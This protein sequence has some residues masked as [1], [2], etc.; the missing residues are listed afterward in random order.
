MTAL[1]L[2]G[3]EGASLPTGWSIVNPSDFAEASELRQEFFGFLDAW[4]D[5]AGRDGRSFNELF[6]V[7]DGYS[8]W[9]T[10]VAADRQ[11]TRGVVKYFRYAALVDRAVARWKPDSIL[12]FTKDPLFAT[13]LRSRAQH[14]G[15]A[16]QSLQGC[17][18]PVVSTV[19]TGRE[20]L[21]RSFWHALASP[22]QRLA[23]A[24]RCRWALR[25][26][27]LFQRSARPTVVFAS[28]WP[29][30]LAVRNGQ[31]SRIYW[32]EIATAL[33][34][35]EPPLVQAYLPRK[36]EEI[37]DAGSSRAG[38]DAIKRVRA[39][40]LIWERFFPLRGAFSR[41][42]RQIDLLWRFTRL[43]Q[44]TEFHESFRYANTNLA[45]V[46][47]PDLKTGVARAIDWSFKAAQ[48]G[49]ALRAAGDVKVVLVSEEM[50]QPAMPTLSAA[51]ALGIP[52][53]GVQHGTIMPTHFMYALP[54]GH[55]Q[56]A[57]V[58]DYFCAYGEYATEVLSV[59]GCYPP[60]RVWITGA[61]RLDPLVTRLPDQSAARAALELPADA[62]IV[63]LATQ[64]FPWF[65]SAMRAVLECMREHP[66]ALLCLKR[67][68]S[69]HAMPLTQ[70]EAMAADLGVRNVRGFEA[71]TELLLAACSVWISAS[72]TTILEATLIGRPTICLNFS[73][74]P[75]RYPDVEEGVSMSARGVGELK[76]ALAHVLSPAGADP[77]EKRRLAFLKRHLGPTIDGC[78]A[79]TLARRVAGL[80]AG[81]R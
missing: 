17:A 50:Y 68:P 72:S 5:R 13:L 20:W 6:T 7:G 14:S 23:F 19:K 79:A 49:A 66:E 57:P 3:G 33:D 70:I 37:V 63:V 65:V 41:I 48:V 12:L 24:L 39:P 9:W 10:T 11:A 26:A 18:D 71:H 80:A 60:D 52:S 30:H 29:R 78:A 62:R 35:V 61:A 42:A 69:I 4:P 64:T 27:D 36:V 55:V 8:L 51:K 25:H 31:F 38:L 47:L 59:H 45:P 58:P 54:R 43:A 77:C 16:V 73:G 46:L 44:R 34:A 15:T 28:T 21:L 1:G 32:D 2:N 53:V 22:F 40:L 76:T 74:Q 81:S 56:H 67:N 75:D